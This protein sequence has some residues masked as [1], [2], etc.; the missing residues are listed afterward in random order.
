MD[1]IFQV[2]S[3]T[4]AQPNEIFAKL[5]VKKEPKNEPQEATVGEKADW[6]EHCRKMEKILKE[7]REM[8]ELEDE[9]PDLDVN[10]SM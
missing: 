9:I 6:E 4:T 3:L 5:G 2:F 1:T 8:D 7:L 10:F